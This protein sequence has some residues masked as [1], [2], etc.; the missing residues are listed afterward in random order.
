MDCRLG[1]LGPGQNMSPQVIVSA[2]NNDFEPGGSPSTLPCH[3]VFVKPLCV[4]RKIICVMS[5]N[6]FLR[7]FH[8]LGVML[9][10]PRIRRNHDRG[11]WR[12]VAAEKTRDHALMERRVVASKETKIMP[13]WSKGTLPPRRWIGTLNLWKR[14]VWLRYLG[15]RKVSYWRVKRQ[16]IY[17]AWQ[18]DWCAIIT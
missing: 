13:A 2:R 14:F 18:L 10:P 6:W 5:G 12:T 3:Q 11:K 1:L 8:T 17:D 16:E 4:Y 15:I 9:M 7:V